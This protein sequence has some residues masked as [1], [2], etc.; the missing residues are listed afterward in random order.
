MRD[1]SF[2]G[3]IVPLIS[4]AAPLAEGSTAEDSV[5]RIRLDNFDALFA[6]YSTIV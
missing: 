3:R 1:S 2:F 4:E 5:V 6:Q